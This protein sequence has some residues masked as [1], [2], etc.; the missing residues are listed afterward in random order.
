MFEIKKGRH[1]RPFLLGEK[2]LECDGTALNLVIPAQA[3]I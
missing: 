2:Y 1:C 3:G